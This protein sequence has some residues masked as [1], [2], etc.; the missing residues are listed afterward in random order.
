M[1]SL[2]VMLLMVPLGYCD[3]GGQPHFGSHHQPDIGSE[4]GTTSSTTAASKSTIASTTPEDK[5]TKASTTPEDKSTEA[6]A[7]PVD[8]STIA[9]T[10]PEDKSTIVSTTP[11][12]KSTIASTTSV[13]NIAVSVNS[14]C[15][16]SKNLEIRKDQKGK[17]EILSRKRRV[18]GGQDV[19][20]SKHPWAVRILL[21]DSKGE[22][23]HICGGTLLANGW[24]LSAAHCFE[25]SITS[26]L[27]FGIYNPVT[28]ERVF[29]KALIIL[30]HPSFDMSKT[31][32]Y[33][34]A[35]VKLRIPKSILN[36]LIPACSSPTLDIDDIEA[37]AFGWGREEEDE[38][39]TLSQNLKDINLHIYPNRECFYRKVKTVVEFD[40]D[41]MVCAGQKDRTVKGQSTC[42]GDSGSGLMVL[43]DGTNC[44]SA[45][46]G[47]VSW[48]FGCG[49][50]K[51]R[52]TVFQRV[53]PINTWIQ[54]TIN[55]F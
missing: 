27:K 15:Q 25:D 10:T 26:K 31:L 29:H 40:E 35:L 51:D 37:T 50:R 22:D 24:V 34:A 52:P 12:D 53:A 16:I 20:D 7:T 2:L 5:S 32:S 19:E 45:V 43:A 3:H 39:S 49:G 28:G 38:K 4:S 13:E 14:Q 1:K 54:Q 41:L 46:V 30:S 17:S 33:D 23:S 11:E 55:R 18:V 42:K 9:S 44:K 6:S 47:I 8:K 48:G 21:T 36:Q